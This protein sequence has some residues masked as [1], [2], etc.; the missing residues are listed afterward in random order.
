[1][2]F[3]KVK[4]QKDNYIYIYTSTEVWEDFDYV[5]Y[6]FVFFW[7]LDSVT[8]QSFM[9]RVLDEKAQMQPEVHRAVCNSFY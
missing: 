3:F 1:M 7:L 6:H 5:M 4:F 2:F 9:S 8:L